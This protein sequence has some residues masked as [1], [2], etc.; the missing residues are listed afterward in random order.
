MAD[1]TPEAESDVTSAE[2]TYNVPHTA[3]CTADTNASKLDSL[4]G[5]HVD[6]QT[7]G[8]KGRWC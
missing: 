7:V 1:S 4:T 8:R 3:G 2:H 6:V 5:M